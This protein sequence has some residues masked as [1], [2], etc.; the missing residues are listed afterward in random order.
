ML[1]FQ[2]KDDPNKIIRQSHGNNTRGS[3][4]P[5]M[6]SRTSVTKA[7]KNTLKYTRPKEVYDEI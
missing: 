5:Y 2:F 6:R 7:A 1:C 4:K 3:A